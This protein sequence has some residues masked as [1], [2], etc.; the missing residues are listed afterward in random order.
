MSEIEKITANSP[1]ASSLNITQQNIKQ[2]K[3][4]FPDVFSEN[5]IDFEALK[6]I[7]GEEIDNSEERYSFTWNGKNKARQI[8]QTPSTGT[9]RPS[10]E[11]SVN[12]D[13]TENLFIEGDNLEVLKLLQK[14]Y[15]KK[16]KMIYIDP[17]Y[18]T[19]KDFVYKDNFHDSINNYLEQTGQLD[20]S[21]K[22]I[23]TNSDTSGRYHSSWLN[24]IYPRLKLAKNLLTDDGAIF[25]SID[26]TEQKNLKAVC[27]EVFGEDNFI[28]MFIWKRRASSAMADNNVS[29]DQ[30][31]VLCYQK[32]GL[33]N[34]KGVEKDFDKYKNPDNDPRGPW[35]LGDLTVGMNASMR[36]NQAYDLVDPETGNVFPF[37][38]NRVWAFIPESMKKMI[39]EERVYFP[40][41]PSQRPMQKRFRD[42]L[43]SDHNPISTLLMDKVG[44]NTEATKV[45][46]DLMGGNIFEYSKPLSLL[47]TLI[48]QV[49]VDD[50][51]IVLDFFAGSCTTAQAVMELNV[52]SNKNLKYIMVQL[53]E[54]CEKTSS[55]FKAGYDKVSDIGKERIKR[56]I[57]SLQEKEVKNVDAGFKVLKLDETNIRPWDADFDNLEKMLQQAAESI[58]A[59]RSNEDVLYEILLKY[60]IEL[61]VSVETKTVD[62]KKVFIVGAGDLIVCLDDNITSETVEGIAML[63]DE[64]VR[65]TTQ[66]VFKDAGFTDSNVK[67]N[68]IQILKQAGIDD[69]KSI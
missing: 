43:K 35:V 21:G 53:P 49:C 50:N 25:I 5:K 40:K 32:G 61:T 23:S 54:P 4:L 37:N 16:V 3:Q 39:N 30:D 48:P 55:A 63:K 6:A 65:E 15:H 46:Q 60:G 69:I 11:E 34:L 2:L 51:D 31:Y 45:I 62:S 20:S 26:D 28:G 7:L 52:S 18:N 10:K 27:D 22:K 64:L 29:I 56:V 67:T 8:A 57:N 9:L 17:P 44:L 59:N 13:T 36:P 19:G 41:D 66:V 68:A 38:P 12:W 1:E 58:K 33:E 24:M 47:K 14:S 42:E